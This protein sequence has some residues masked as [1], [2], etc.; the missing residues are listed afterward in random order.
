MS[1]QKEPVI[2]IVDIEYLKEPYS[3]D[4]EIPYID[5]D[6]SKP[7][8]SE[9]S[10]VVLDGIYLCNHS[11]VFYKASPTHKEEND[12]ICCAWFRLPCCDGFITINLCTQYCGPTKFKYRCGDCFH[13]S[14]N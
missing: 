8:E 12:Y 4:P 11:S 3:I 10:L 7:E 13:T 14:V 9:D 1:E 2:K 6:S 5:G